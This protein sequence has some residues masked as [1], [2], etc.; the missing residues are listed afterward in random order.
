MGLTINRRTESGLT[1]LH[2]E[3]EL[4]IYTVGAFRSESDKLDPG[5]AQVVVDLS[6]VSLLDSS[7]LGALVS[8]LNRARA[9]GG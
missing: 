4:D 8:L 1:I 5:E 3:G 6:D 9:G 2:L 7:G